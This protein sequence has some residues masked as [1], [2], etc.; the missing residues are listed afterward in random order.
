M[1]DLTKMELVIVDK[2]C[3]GYSNKEIA[4]VLSVSD[5]TVKFHLTNIF[6]KENVRSRAQLICKYKF[7]GLNLEELSK[8]NV[9]TIFTHIRIAAKELES[10]SNY[11][12]SIL[13]T[14]H[15]QPKLE[16]GLRSLDSDKATV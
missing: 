3:H 14:R 12:A 16:A 6:K 7:P 13:A 2:V 8:E 5:K 9:A 10:A 15:G 4:R 11:L 1:K